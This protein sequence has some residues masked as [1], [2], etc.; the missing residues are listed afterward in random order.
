MSFAHALAW[1]N[2]RI[3]LSIFYFVI[4]VPLGLLLKMV[5]YKRKGPGITANH[6]GW[7]DYRARQ[8]DKRHYENTF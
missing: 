8:R 6:S 1:V 3:L 4:V 2:T 5:R 7:E